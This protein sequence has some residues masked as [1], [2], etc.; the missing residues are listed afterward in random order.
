MF[1]YIWNS[2]TIINNELEEI[3]W[4]IFNYVIIVV[5]ENGQNKNFDSE[6]FVLFLRSECKTSKI[7]LSC[8]MPATTVLE[9]LNLFYHILIPNY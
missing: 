3:Q 8:E 2:V 6:L 9:F 5:N 7:D 1:A 4:S